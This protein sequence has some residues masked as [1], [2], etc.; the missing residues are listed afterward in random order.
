MTSYPKDNLIPNGSK[1]DNLAVDDWRKLMFFGRP[2][3]PLRNVAGLCKQ[4]N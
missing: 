3:E 4:D 2:C 1:T